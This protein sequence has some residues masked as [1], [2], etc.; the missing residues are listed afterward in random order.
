M[1]VVT[2]KGAALI[3]VALVATTRVFKATGVEATSQVRVA[4]RGKMPAT[5]KMAMMELE[6]ELTTLQSV[7]AASFAIFS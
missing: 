7:A 3:R 6:R 2:I 5:T 1:V 4:K